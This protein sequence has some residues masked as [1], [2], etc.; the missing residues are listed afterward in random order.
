MSRFGVTHMFWNEQ[1]KANLGISL[2]NEK[3]VLNKSEVL[4][5]LTQNFCL[6]FYGN[7]CETWK[8]MKLSRKI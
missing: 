3:T 2:K 1:T 8:K 7:K 5:K 6:L 4:V